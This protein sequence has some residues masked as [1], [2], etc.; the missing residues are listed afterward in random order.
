MK[1]DKR[2]VQAIYGAKTPPVSE[3]LPLLFL[4][5]ELGYKPTRRASF[6]APAGVPRPPVDSEPS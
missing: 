3:I 6:V 1:E 5:H 2:G 4:G